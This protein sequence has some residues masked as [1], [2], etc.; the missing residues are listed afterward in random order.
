MSAQ[1]V[2]SFA[3]RPNPTGHV[4]QARAISTASFFTAVNNCDQ[5]LLFR[6]P[7]MRPKTP[8]PTSDNPAQS[9]SNDSSVGN[10]A[11]LHNALHMTSKENTQS[12]KERI[13]L[14]CIVFKRACSK[15][16][17]YFSCNNGIFSM[18]VQVLFSLFP[19]PLSW[20]KDSGSLGNLKWKRVLLRAFVFCFCFFILTVSIMCVNG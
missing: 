5:L 1:D 20:I 17:I 3:S 18:C 9:Y 2:Q 11:L 6:G 16:P 4:I 8:L 19:R 10:W 13:Y 15:L 12:E 7:L 14:C